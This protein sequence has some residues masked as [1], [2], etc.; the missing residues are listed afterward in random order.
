VTY[1]QEKYIAQCLQ[2]LVDQETDFPFEII[3]GDDC[4]TDGTRGIVSDFSKKYSHIVRPVF[5]EKN[6]GPSCNY[7]SVH[8]LAKGE[9]VAHLDGDDF[10]MP[11]K[12]QVQSDY[13]DANNSCQIVWHRMGI[14]N[15]M[16]GCMHYQEYNYDLLAEKMICIN[17]LIS[18]ITA[19]IHSSKMYRRCRNS[20]GVNIDALDFSENIMHLAYNHGYAAFIPSGVYGV[21]RIDSGISR[22]RGSIR[23]KIYKWLMF[24]YDES[25]GDKKVIAAKTLLLVLSD[26][27][28]K[29][30]SLS[31][32]LS[33]L[34][35]MI[36]SISLSEIINCRN[37]KLPLSLANSND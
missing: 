6:I 29:S 14:L 33:V 9:Y 13:L 18:N 34:V 3:V 19:G 10:S 5:H 20:I 36:G 11:G 30:S 26:V 37:N 35:R 7:F 24:F 16:T 28:H 31:F 8:G 2:S 21:Y 1:N 17:D 22:N 25:I 23:I 27:K 4:S 15:N 12:L 32:G